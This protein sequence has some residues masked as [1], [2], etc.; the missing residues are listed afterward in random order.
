MRLYRI[1]PI[2]RMLLIMNI[3][4]TKAVLSAMPS[5]LLALFEL[6]D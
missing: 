6:K 5:L 4:R 3:H 2:G 1:Q